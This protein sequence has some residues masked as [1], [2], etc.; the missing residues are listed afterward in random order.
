MYV[1]IDIPTTS[2]LESIVW[3]SS[4]IHILIVTF[5]V[6]KIG[7]YFT[8]VLVGAP[9]SEPCILLYFR[10]YVTRYCK[11]CFSDMVARDRSKL[12][13]NFMPPYTFNL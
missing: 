13:Y 2:Q 10:R 12:V 11:K 5:C 4:Y 8:T 3:D 6:K 9:D 7:Y 1:I